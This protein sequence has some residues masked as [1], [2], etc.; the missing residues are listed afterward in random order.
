MLHIA[1]SE[2]LSAALQESALMCLVPIRG[3]G[4]KQADQPGPCEYACASCGTCGRKSKAQPQGRVPHQSLWWHKG[5][6]NP[7]RSCYIPPW[8]QV[9]V[10]ALVAGCLDVAGGSPRRFLF[11]VLAHFASDPVEAER[12]RYFASPQG[13]TDL[14][15][16]NQREGAPFTLF[17]AGGS[18]LM[19]ALYVWD[20][21]WVYSAGA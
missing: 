11:Q 20:I 3:V 12:L 15:R 7:D 5:L 2:I 17:V 6:P 1:E 19:P 10:C 8:P 9:R 16:Y 18:F 14:S 13:R 21:T 4:K